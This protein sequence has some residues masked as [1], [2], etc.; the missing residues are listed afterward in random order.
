LTD[1]MCS[2]IDIIKTKIEGVQSDIE[3]VDVSIKEF[4]FFMGQVSQ[5]MRDKR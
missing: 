2:K 3:K 4:T 5:Y 1:A